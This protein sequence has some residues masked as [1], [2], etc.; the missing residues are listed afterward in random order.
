MLEVR[1]GKHGLQIVVTD[2]AVLHL[3]RIESVEDIH[4]ADKT[5]VLF[6]DVLKAHVEAFFRTCDCDG[7]WKGRLLYPLALYEF[8]EYLV[9]SFGC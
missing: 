4:V 3:E 5:N 6:V 8:D 1:V 7:M 9:D 2:G